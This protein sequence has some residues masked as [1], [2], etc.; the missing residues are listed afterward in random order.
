M[1]RWKASGIHLLLSVVIVGAVLL[2]MLSVWYP[3]PLFEAAGGSHL[4]FILAAVDV[5][6][7]PLLT[8]IVFKSGKKSLKFDLTVIAILQ[9]AALVYGVQIVYRARPI[10][11]VFTVDRFEVVMAKDI[12][13]K[14]LAKVTRAEFRRLPLGSPRVIAVAA[15][16]EPRLNNEV[17]SSALAGKDLQMFPQYYVEYSQLTAQALAKARPVQ[18]LRKRDAATLDAFLQTRKL[19][20]DA[21][22]FLPLHAMKRDGAVIVDAKT[23]APLKTLLIDPW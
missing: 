17:L 7:G 1:S 16:T 22:R 23:A 2:F 20:D 5:T 3:Q 15:P 21:V 13:P 12:D 10:Y 11:L 14:D 8:A 19:T 4:I 18:I 6:I 9:L